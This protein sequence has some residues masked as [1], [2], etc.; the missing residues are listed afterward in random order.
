MKI[1][2]VASAIFLMMCISSVHSLTLKA[3]PKRKCKLRSDLGKPKLELNFLLDKNTIV[4][5]ALSV[6]E[7]GK[8]GI[9][10]SVS[11]CGVLGT[12]SFNKGKITWTVKLHDKKPFAGEYWIML[13]VSTTNR[14]G[15]HPHQGNPGVWGVSVSHNRNGWRTLGGSTSWYRAPKANFASY[16]D[17]ITVTLDADEGTLNLS[18]KEFKDEITGLPKGQNFWPYFDAYDVDFTLQV[19]GEPQEEASRRLHLQPPQQL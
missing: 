3:L 11:H 5:P 8:T 10:S 2:L 14:V 7:D 19:G 15:P 9:K 6:S 4:G 12:K 13:G 18:S 1:Y 16:G 17:V